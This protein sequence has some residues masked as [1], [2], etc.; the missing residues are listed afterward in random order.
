MEKISADE[1]RWK[2]QN[3]ADTLR[4]AAEIQADSKRFSGAKQELKSQ[5]KE[6]QRAI[7]IPGK[8]YISKET[9]RHGKKK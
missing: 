1:R 2:R 5:I 7:G 3:D 9:F 6:S 8:G 4:R